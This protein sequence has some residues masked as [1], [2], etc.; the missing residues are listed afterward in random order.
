MPEIVEVKISKEL[1]LPLVKDHYISDI[2]LFDSGRYSIHSPENYDKFILSIKSSP[3]KINNIC[4]KGKFMYWE[5]SNSF[6]MFSTFG[7]TG[8]WS[9]EIGNHPCLSIVEN[10]KEILYFNDP[11]HFGTIKFTNNK[12]ELLQ[13]LASFGWEP[14]QDDFATWEPYLNKTIK[15]SN[16]TIS[17]LL[18]DQGIFAG[19]GNYIK[20]ESLYK[21][22]ISPW[23]IGKSLS[24]DDIKRLSMAIIEVINISY[25]HQGA[26]I[27]TYK[28]PFGEEGKYS[29]LFEVYGRKLDPFNNPVVSEQT[30]DKRTT[31]WVKNIQI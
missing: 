23:R 12:I 30:P 19:V 11:R 28:T 27:A 18:M 20:C 25:Q 26:T 13:K 16:K 14:F 29:S 17:E 5:F 1:I 3:T 22:K 31:H 24:S 8:Q 21:S 9:P 6:Y 4:T 2:K 7:M 10:N 15:K